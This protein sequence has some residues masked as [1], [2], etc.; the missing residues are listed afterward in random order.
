MFRLEKKLFLFFFRFIILGICFIMM[1]I[2]SLEM[3]LLRIG[4]DMYFVKCFNFN[5]EK[6]IKNIV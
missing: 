3:N 5:M 2:L 4:V 1:E 6:R